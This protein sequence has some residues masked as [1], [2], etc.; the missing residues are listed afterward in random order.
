MRR[1]KHRHLGSA[2][3]SDFSPEERPLPL[4]ASL[5]EF[6]EEEIIPA[7]KDNLRQTF[8]EAPASVKA[9]SAVTAATGVV[10]AVT[11]DISLVNAVPLTTVVAPGLPYARKGVEWL[12]ENKESTGTWTGGPPSDVPLR[13]RIRQGAHPVRGIRNLFRAPGEEIRDLGLRARLWW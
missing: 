10:G 9:A 13:Q 7:A 8:R 1:G 12:A 11:G 5:R 4:L 2:Q 6:S 3:W